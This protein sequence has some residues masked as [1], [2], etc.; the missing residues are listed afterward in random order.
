MEHI[1]SGTLR[2]LNASMAH[3]QA[4]TH[5]KHPVLQ[6]LLE[7]DEKCLRF[8]LDLYS[9]HRCAC[10]KKKKQGSKMR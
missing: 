6:Y 8:G 2:A 4:I 3:P 10:F 1:Y 9:V 5:D 7:F